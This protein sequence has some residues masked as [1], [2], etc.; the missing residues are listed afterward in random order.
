MFTLF[1]ATHTRQSELRPGE[2]HL[3][4]A[5]VAYI[6]AVVVGIAAV[7]AFVSAELPLDVLVTAF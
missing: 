6:T 2:P 4:G 5:V 1:H 7:A 3:A